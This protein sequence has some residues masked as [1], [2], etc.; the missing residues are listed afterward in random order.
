MK[1]T[2]MQSITTYIST[3]CLAI[4]APRPHCWMSLLLFTQC[5]HV[6]DYRFYL[7]IGCLTTGSRPSNLDQRY[8]KGR[9]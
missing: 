3:R 9:N 2:L 6:S 8:V 7:L 4:I 1:G 5:F